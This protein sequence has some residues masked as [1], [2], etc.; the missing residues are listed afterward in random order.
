MLSA[1]LVVLLPRRDTQNSCNTNVANDNDV[2]AATLNEFDVNHFSVVSLPGCRWSD[3]GVS[4]TS[5]RVAVRCLVENV[6][7][8]FAVVEKRLGEVHLMLCARSL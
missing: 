2:A 7:D 1:I 6:S 3:S 4:P 5:I 8:E